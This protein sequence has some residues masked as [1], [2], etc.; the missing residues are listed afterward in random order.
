MEGVGIFSVPGGMNYIGEFKNGK[1]EGHGTLTYSDGRK[2]VGEFRNNK[3]WSVTE[4]D[5]NGEI[6]GKYVD[7]IKKYLKKESIK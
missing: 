4:Y 7:G 6:I 2:K 3:P 1:N 5:I